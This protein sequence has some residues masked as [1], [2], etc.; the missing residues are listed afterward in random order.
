MYLHNGRRLEPTLR[1]QNPAAALGIIAR[2]SFVSILPSYSVQAA[3]T[4]SRVEART[5]TDF[6][7]TQWVQGVLHK[8]KCMTPLIQ[9]FWDVVR[10]TFAET[11]HL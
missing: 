2:S 4:S 3:V 10:E 5:I 7:Q 9:G 11:L 1:L 6:A 8:D